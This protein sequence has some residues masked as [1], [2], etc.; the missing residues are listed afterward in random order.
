MIEL[1]MLEEKFGDRSEISLTGLES[2]K[3]KKKTE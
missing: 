3:K 2:T 1:Q